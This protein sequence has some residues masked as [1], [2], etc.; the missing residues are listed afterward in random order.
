M[1]HT[2]INLT[3]VECY[4]VFTL[5]KGSQ[6]ERF[7]TSAFP[8]SFLKADSDHNN[9]LSK[10]ALDY[11]SH[12]ITSTIDFKIA[13]NLYNSGRL[14]YHDRTGVY[15]DS[16]GKLTSYK[17]F[18]LCD[19]KVYWKEDHCTVYAEA[20]N[21]FNTGYY[22]Y[23]GIIQPGLWIMA[24]IVVDLWIIRNSQKSEIRNQGSGIRDDHNWDIIR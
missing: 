20:S 9:M 17:P 14:T 13:R 12:Q 18:W 1:N 7:Q 24:G 2:Q 5:S 4:V 19:S 3:G 23:G 10:Y 6:F 8:Y 21:I 16:K 15:E 11:L 22:D